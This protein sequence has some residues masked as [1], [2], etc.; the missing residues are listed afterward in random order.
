MVRLLRLPHGQ[1]SVGLHTAP[2]RR[3]LCNYLC[4]SMLL[5]QRCSQQHALNPILSRGLNDQI[6]GKPGFSSAEKMCGVG[7]TFVEDSNGALYVKSLVP[8]GSAAQSG[9]VQVCLH[10]RLSVCVI[11]GCERVCSCN[12][13]RRRLLR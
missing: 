3:L 11:L 5:Q 12:A 4:C 13:V 10:P 7:I 9:Q 1:E 2:C 6:P 8:G